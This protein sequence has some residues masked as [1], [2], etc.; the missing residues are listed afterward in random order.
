M[1][2]TSFS[3]TPSPASATGHS[4]ALANWA[5][6][7]LRRVLH[8]QEGFGPG[9][10]RR[11]GQRTRTLAARVQDELPPPTATPETAADHL[12]ALLLR[13]GQW[14]SA[15]FFRPYRNGPGPTLWVRRHDGGADALD[16]ERVE[17]LLERL[18]RQPED[19]GLEPTRVMA[20][21]RRQLH[22]GMSEAELVQVLTLTSPGQAAVLRRLCRHAD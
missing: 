7:Q 13:E 2:P 6:E 21:A 4:A 19:A 3:S 20:S 10:S 17:A 5:V 11:V 16:R 14:A 15:R 12:W 8:L 1:T 9:A 22:D 18:C